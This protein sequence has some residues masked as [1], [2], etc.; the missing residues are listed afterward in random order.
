M[1]HLA[2]GL[3]LDIL[4]LAVASLDDGSRVE[5]LFGKN[6][7]GAEGSSTAG[8]DAAS[9]LKSSSPQRPTGSDADMVAVI[10]Q[11]GTKISSD[12]GLQIGLMSAVEEELDTLRRENALL[13]K[14]WCGFCVSPTG[15]Q[16]AIHRLIDERE[17]H[18]PKQQ[19]QAEAAPS[20]FLIRPLLTSTPPG[21]SEG[22]SATGREA[23]RAWNSCCCCCR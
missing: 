23:H 19:K 4:S 15:S 12:G 1:V 21:A 2:K 5:G 13:R 20:R 11:P 17:K 6:F 10:V 7:E 14:R 3:S 9:S 22:L 8:H 18:K 16:I